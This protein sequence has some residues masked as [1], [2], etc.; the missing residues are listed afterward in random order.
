MKLAL[1]KHRDL[2]L[3]FIAL[4]LIGVVAA[5]F[6]WGIKEIIIS[7]NAALKIDLK[8]GVSAAFDLDQAEAIL[9]ARKLLE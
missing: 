2:I 7:L 4:V 6:I 3:V 8:S 5:F 9:R 1:K